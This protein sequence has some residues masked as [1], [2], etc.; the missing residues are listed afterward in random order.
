MAETS[1]LPSTERLDSFVDAVLAIIVT[2]M[3]VELSVPG[4]K[5]IAQ[6]E[7]GSALLNLW[8]DYLAFV[9]SFLLVG[10]VWASHHFLW[11]L[12]RVTDKLLLFLVIMHLMFV[13]FVPFV[14]QLLADQFLSPPHERTVSSSI[15]AVSLLLNGISFNLCWWHIQKQGF[16]SEEVSFTQRKAI[17]KRYLMGPLAA[18]LALGLAFVSFWLSLSIYVLLIVF[19]FW[20]GPEVAQPTQPKETA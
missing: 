18:L 10:Q 15:Y 13:S 1:G 12:V 4:E 2:L 8:P 7:L 9:F 11:R 3:A 16:L 6:Q 20:P 17:S 5:A 14:T 19:Y